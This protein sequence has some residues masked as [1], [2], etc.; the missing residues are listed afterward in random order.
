M[1]LLG[2]WP[3]DGARGPVMTNEPGPGAQGW[4][5]GR[6]PGMATWPLS[7][8]WDMGPV[9]ATWPVPGSRGWLNGLGPGPGDGYMV[10]VWLLGHGPGDV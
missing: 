7:G 10:V 8:Y 6:G 9:M 4:L 5:N 1:W 2:P 3:L